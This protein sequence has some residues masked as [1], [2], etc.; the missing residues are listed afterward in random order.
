LKAKQVV[1]T[2]HSSTGDASLDAQPVSAPGSRAGKTDKVAPVESVDNSSSSG[3]NTS[4]GLTGFNRGTLPNVQDRQADMGQ[5][6]RHSVTHNDNETRNTESQ[7]ARISTE[8]NGSDR[9]E[10]CV[11]PSWHKDDERKKQKKEMKRMEREKRELEK[12]LKKLADAESKRDSISQKRESRRLTKKQ[13]L[14]SSSRASSVKADESRSSCAPRFSTFSGS[15]R[16][17]RSSSFNGPEHRHSK[18]QW[19]ETTR[20]N[21]SHEVNSMA[22]STMPRLSSALPERFGAAISRELASRNTAACSGNPPT[23]QSQRSLHSTTKF[24]DLRGSARLL[25][26]IDKEEIQLNENTVSFYQT[27]VSSK[28]NQFPAGTSGENNLSRVENQKRSTDLDRLSFA[29]SLNLE[30]RVYSQEVPK[31]P[32]FAGDTEEIRESFVKTS[33]TVS[34]NRPTF[35]QNKD[36]N[37][38]DSENLTVI[39]PA[40]AS[41]VANSQTRISTYRK[42]PPAEAVTT[43]VKTSTWSTHTRDNSPR[44]S[45]LQAPNGN[46][47]HT[48]FKSS[49]LAA[50]GTTVHDLERNS[51]INEGQQISQKTFANPVPVGDLQAPKFKTGKQILPLRLRRR[52]KGGNP[53]KSKNTSQSDNSKPSDNVHQRSTS[54]ESTQSLDRN[55]KI[56]EKNSRK[57]AG[58]ALL[59]QPSPAP[60]PGHSIVSGQSSGQ[61][62]TRPTSGNSRGAADVTYPSE[63]RGFPS[64]ANPQD[65]HTEHYPPRK[66]PTATISSTTGGPDTFQ[67]GNHSSQQNASPQPP[68]LSSH[69]ISMSQP[70]SRNSSQETASEDYNTALE[71]ISTTAGSLEQ[72]PS[73]QFLNPAPPSPMPNASDESVPCPPGSTTQVNSARTLF[74]LSNNPASAMQSTAS[75]ATSGSGR[76]PRS[77]QQARPL[78]K[79]FVICCHCKFWHDMPSEVYA[80][81]AFPDNYLDSQRHESST[82]LVD[83]QGDARSRHFDKMNNLASKD[84]QGSGDSAPSTRSQ[85]KTVFFNRSS[86]LPTVSGSTVTCCWC[87]HSMTKSCCEGWTT[88]VYM[89]E[90]HH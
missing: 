59:T 70:M 67:Q 5:M 90:R 72:I 4:S 69:R 7:Q 66:D 11:S 39:E 49:P 20:P 10:I 84:V 1:D 14:G 65:S 85:N 60:A 56:P 9:S 79:I 31:K 75:L 47:G 68:E 37:L 28:N 87:N 24:T 54:I 35:A 81:L 62:A 77:S 8:T 18:E 46:R 12:R 40:R 17:S 25:Q 19:T 80:K 21:T 55:F 71:N 32:N 33:A 27:P 73:F 78:A 63:N 58:S 86:T 52:E 43:I 44:H 36:K 57:N 38:E 13:P 76:K 64:L 48:R 2:S 82:T 83:L 34:V 29:A 26:S 42:V 22:T 74:H 53:D 45:M 15:T 88:V 89:H 30:K 16:A 41:T 6:L 23:N 50:P 61:S 3:I 51:G